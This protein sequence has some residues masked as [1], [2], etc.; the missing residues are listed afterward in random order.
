V[1]VATATDA[2]VARL[3]AVQLRKKDLEDDMEQTIKALLAKYEFDYER[4][5]EELAQ[6]H[7]KVWREMEEAH[8]LNPGKK[9]GIN[10]ES[11]EIYERIKP[12]PHRS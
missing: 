3:K 10:L 9:Y 7:K 12:S 6:E 11:R 5:N 8:G 4:T 2:Q 1:V